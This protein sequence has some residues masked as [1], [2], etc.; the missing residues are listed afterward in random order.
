MEGRRARPRPLAERSSLP[1]RLTDLGYARK[2]ARVLAGGFGV[3]TILVAGFAA[4]VVLDA[5]IGMPA[6]VRAVILL[7]TLV[8]AGVLFLR[9]VWRPLR[10][11]VRPLHV[12]HL[13]EARFPKLNDS[14]ASA[15]DFLTATESGNTSARF[16]RIAVVRAQRALEKCDTSRLIPSGRAWQRFWLAAVI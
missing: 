14:L 10:Q 3:L 15:A 8:A 13:L 12:A 9:D 6:V 7:G 1:T 4:G 16:Q 2:T 11:P 5:T